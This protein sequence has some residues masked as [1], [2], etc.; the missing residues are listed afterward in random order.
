VAGADQLSE[1]LLQAQRRR[2]AGDWPAAQKL[3]A[4]AAGLAPADPS[5]QHNLALS[6]FALGQP[7]AAL[8]HVEAAILRAPRQWQSHVLAARIQRA[9]GEIDACCVSLTA[10]LALDPGNGS[11]RIAM[12]DLEINEFGDSQNATALVLPLRGHGHH[13][14]D[15]ELTTLMALFYDR[16]DISAEVLSDRLKRFSA[17]HLRLPPAISQASAQR[18]RGRA[19]L[20]VGLLSPLLSSSPVH[21]LTYS[22][23]AALAS[24]FDLI[25]FNR[26]SK[27]DW[28]TVQ[29]RALCCGWHDVASLGAEDLAGV[30]AGEAIDVLF[31]LGGWSDAVGLRALSARPAR[32]ILTWVGGQSA[33]TGLTN[34]DGWIGDTWQNPVACDGLYTE[35]VLRMVGGYVDYT[36]P[37]VLASVVA[38]Q[39][40]QSG[41]VLAGNPVKIGAEL[42]RHWPAGVTRVSLLDRRYRHPRTLARVTALLTAAGI[43]ID[44]VIAPN[45][46]R[47]YLAALSRFATLVDTRPYGAGLTAIE[48][49]ALGLDVRSTASEGRL[50]SQ[51]HQASH[52]HTT[53]RNPGLARQIAALI[54]AG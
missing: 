42:I 35:P 52:A 6:Q 7:D 18:S 45:G 28:A 39:G 38:A 21:A 54:T 49:M 31:D 53:G 11:A 1:L 32:R 37:P 43:A 41:V 34:T 50:F 27:E 12:A 4:Y 29:F 36:P 24:D 17:D 48:A 14:A 30:I 40:R 26:S 44:A 25:A 10:V 16:E 20:R 46:H 19:R 9:R 2:N 33:T 15:A 22:T 13:A 47:D 23:F 5:I 8:R 3:F 51:R